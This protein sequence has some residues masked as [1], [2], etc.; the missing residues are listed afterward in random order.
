MQEIE[1]KHP[2]W[3]V[4]VKE[5]LALRNS[6]YKENSFCEK[7]VDDITDVIQRKGQIKTFKQEQ[8]LSFLFQN[9]LNYESHFEMLEN[10]FLK[11]T[12]DLIKD[13]IAM[14]KQ[15]KLIQEE[16]RAVIIVVDLLIEI[17]NKIIKNA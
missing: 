14:M 4:Q 6:L 9:D 3:L 10:L 16:Y 12:K 15:K 7:I 5:L 2:E 11:F 1:K 13:M 17:V 8:E